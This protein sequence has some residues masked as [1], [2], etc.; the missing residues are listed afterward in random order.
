MM[1]KQS[2]SSSSED[3]EVS[4]FNV[5]PVDTV[6][7]SVESQSEKLLKRQGRIPIQEQWTQV[8]SLNDDEQQKIKTFVI[9][10]D[11]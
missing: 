3:I 8:I 10:T 6:Q 9:A 5:D 4:E 7:E 2:S 1:L 11:L